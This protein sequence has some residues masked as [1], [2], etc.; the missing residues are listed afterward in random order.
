VRHGHQLMAGPQHQARVAIPEELDDVSHHISWTSRSMSYGPMRC[1]KSPSPPP[2][3]SGWGIS[4]LPQWHSV[5]RRAQLTTQ[6]ATL[7]PLTC[8]PV[9]ASMVAR[10][11]IRAH[12]QGQ[13]SH[14]GG[15]NLII[16]VVLQKEPV[17]QVARQL[18]HFVL[19]LRALEPLA[20]ARIPATG[21]V[22]RL[23]RCGHQ[24]GGVLSA[25]SGPCE[26]EEEG[27]GRSK[28]VMRKNWH[29]RTAPHS[30]VCTRCKCCTRSRPIP[31]D[32]SDK[33][34]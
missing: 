7:P 29:S 32:R 10:Q 3:G 19:Y 20:G 16:V 13:R 18:Q 34:G 1:V 33:T 28:Q 23:A 9:K 30:L 5:G 31:R 17:A 26:W 14:L 24:N 11:D 2:E 6:T 27:P 22:V 25:R 12:P 8:R 21:R 15:T 4:R